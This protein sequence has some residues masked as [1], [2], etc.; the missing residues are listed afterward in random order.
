MILIIISVFL[1][2]IELFGGLGINSMIFWDLV[3]KGRDGRIRRKR[4]NDGRVWELV[5]V[6]M[7]LSNSS[8][9]YCIG[10]I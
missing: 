7:F 4:R 2:D 5:C 6:M 10:C 1:G 8:C 3:G 9:E